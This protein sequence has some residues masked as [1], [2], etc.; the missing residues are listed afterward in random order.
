MPLPLASISRRSFVQ[1]P[2]GTKASVTVKSFDELKST[3]IRI[4]GYGDVGSGKTLAILG[5]LQAGLK[6]LYIPCEIGAGDGLLTLHC[7]M[8]DRGLLDLK[9]NLF[10]V[11]GLRTYADYATFLDDPTT[12]FP[13]VYDVG[14][15]LAAFDSFSVFQLLH[16][17][18]E[19]EPELNKEDTYHEQLKL[20]S[21]AWG[22]LKN[23]TVKNLNRFNRLNNVKTGQAWHKYLTCLEGDKEK[24]AGTG[25]NQTKEGAKLDPAKYTAMTTLMLQGAS[26][27]LTESAFDVIIEMRV[28]EKVA[29]AGNKMERVY[30]YQLQASEKLTAKAR[31]LA[32]DPIEDGDM[33][34]LWQKIQGQAGGFLGAK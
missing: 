3:G 26:K 25:L 23:A 12:D 7:A 15:D 4:L 13:E 6:V 34:K 27:K 10:V 8:Q 17:A 16:V 32:L 9:K 31:G 11:G 19:V 1:G 24:V 29:A 33:F 28:R 14:I 5:F 22:R 18:A 21:Q 2:G 30:E 20:D